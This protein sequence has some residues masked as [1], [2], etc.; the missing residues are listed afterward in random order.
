MISFDS[1]GFSLGTDSSGNLSGGIYV[2]WCWK[3]GGAAVTNTDG[4]LT[5]QVSVNQD[6][7][8]SIATY[9]T[10]DGA[11]TT[12]GHGLGKKPAFALFKARNNSGN[13]AVY[14]QSLG[15]NTIRL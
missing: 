8:F 3:A 10:P 14:H 12:F 9:T 11:A 15:T 2:A 6:A 13:W 1:D 5:S 4:A 7:G